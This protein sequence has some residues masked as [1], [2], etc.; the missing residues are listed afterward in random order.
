[1]ELCEI[2]I[3]SSG[4]LIVTLL[5]FQPLGYKFKSHSTFIDSAKRVVSLALY[6][7]SV[8]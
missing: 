1:M 5:N 7:N 2:Y 3:K 8:S 6:K 4:A